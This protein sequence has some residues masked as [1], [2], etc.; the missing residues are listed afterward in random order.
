[1]LRRFAAILFALTMAGNVWAGV[2][3]CM[4]EAELHRS[5][6]CKR[7]R[8]ERDVM[9]AKPCCDEICGDSTFVSVYR[10]QPDSSTKIPLPKL[11]FHESPD[12]F[13]RSALAQP[14]LAKVDLKRFLG[15]SQIPRP[16]NLYIKHHSLLI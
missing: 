16:P 13:Y 5:S 15:L 1:M 7:E 3:D 14:V 10:T 2:C 6:C 9:S 11:V 8:S 12:P 4:A